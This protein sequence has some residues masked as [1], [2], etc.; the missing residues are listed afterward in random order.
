[1]AAPVLSGR[2]IMKKL[3]GVFAVPVLTILGCSGS[4]NTDIAESSSSTLAT[5]GSTVTQ[6]VTCNSQLF[7]HNE[8]EV[9]TQGG[10]IVDA[11]ITQDQSTPPYLCAQGNSH[12]FTPHSVWVDHGCSAVFEVSIQMPSQIRERIQCASNHQGYTTCQTDVNQI[13]SIQLVRQLSSAPCQL[14]NSFGYGQNYVWVDRGCR[15][16]FEVTGWGGGPG[17]GNDAVVFYDQNNFNGA[18]FAV[19]STV[20][21]FADV[22][23]NDRAQS[24]IIHQGNWEVCQDANF[25]GLCQTFGPGNYSSLGPLGGQISSIRPR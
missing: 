12:G 10:T 23:F 7:R 16:D 6:N 13:T 2:T 14:G 5:G 25:N 11:R 17:P 22:G 18:E 19:N 4:S 15:G 1:M 8:C 9:D 20:P 24:M 3:V 21:N